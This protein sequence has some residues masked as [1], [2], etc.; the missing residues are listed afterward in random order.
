MSALHDSEPPRRPARVIAMPGVKPPKRHPI[1]RALRIV[2]RLVALLVTLSLLATVSLNWW[3]PPATSYMVQSGLPVTYEYVNMDHISR[4]IIAATVAHEDEQIGSR[5]GAFDPGAFFARA[6]AYTI[7]QADPSGSTIPQQL[8]KNIYLWP[9]HDAVRK[10][11]EAVLSEEVAFMVPRKR[12]MELYLNYAQFGPKLYGVCAATWYY[13]NTRP[14]QVTQY[15]AAQLMGVLPDPDNVRRAPG[16]GLDIGPS[17]NKQAVD[18]IN[19][20]ANVWVPRQLAGMGGWWAAV[21]TLG[22]NDTAMDH[23]NSID[24]PG[25]CASMPQSVADRLQAEGKK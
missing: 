13:F 9:S 10:G 15:E 17:A 21:Q 22:I 12:I 14:S 18:L 16:G 2:I 7:G 11:L 3:T 8:V 5:F 23:L 1:R 20:A 4:Y 19:G 25:S 6:Q 24:Q